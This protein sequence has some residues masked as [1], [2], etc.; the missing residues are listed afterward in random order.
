MFRQIEQRNT[1]SLGMPYMGSKR[2]LSKRIV[3]YILEQTP[4]SR[5]QKSPIREV[6]FDMF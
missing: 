3:D 1:M 2:K 6:F 5:C 4:R